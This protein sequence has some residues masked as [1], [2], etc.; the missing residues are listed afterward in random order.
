MYHPVGSLNLYNSNQ[1]MHMFGSC[2]MKYSVIQKDG[3]NFYFLNY[4]WYVNDLYLKEEVL[5]FQIPPLE[6]SLSTQ[7]CSSV[8]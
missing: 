2:F 4:T 7:P 8:S 6:R 3:L 1:Q 5:N